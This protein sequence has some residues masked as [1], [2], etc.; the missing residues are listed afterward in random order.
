MGMLIDAVKVLWR[1]AFFLAA[2]LTVY[3]G[4]QALRLHVLPLVRAGADTMANLREQAEEAAREIDGLAAVLPNLERDVRSLEESWPPWYEPLARWQHGWK[5][6]MARRALGTQERLR[7]E[8]L[9]RRAALQTR[10]AELGQT[11]PQRT[12]EFLLRHGPPGLAVALAVLLLP[13][14]LRTIRYFAVAPL[15]SL[16]API[17]LALPGSGALHCDAPVRRLEVHLGPGERMLVRSSWLKEYDTTAA[18]K[19]T[20]WLW[21]WDAPLVSYAARLVELTRV[22]AG[23]AGARVSLW[24]GSDPDCHIVRLSLVD[25]P[26]L[27][28]HPRNLVALVD[29]PG[30]LR[31]RRRWRLG[32][33]QAWCTLQLRFILVEGSGT[34]V[35]WS[36]GGIEPARP[37][38]DRRGVS[39]ESVAGFDARLAYSVRRNETFW[40]YLRGREPLFDDVFQGDGCYLVSVAPAGDAGRVGA[41]SYWSAFW[42]VVGKI[43]GF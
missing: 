28:F 15:V 17:R 11:W 36:P 23:P 39:Q 4:V 22:E 9:D 37:V 8:A 35:L 10:I 25:H 19:R 12:R 13:L 26:G 5:L 1:L 27:V 38:G 2:V 31:L 7:A 18:T 43:L 34:V 33:L 30:E 6:D 16:A 40:P 24:G 32:S 41:E 14:V 20:Q 21:R 42:E 29:R 3:M